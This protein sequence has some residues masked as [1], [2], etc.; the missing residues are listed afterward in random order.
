MN[1]SMRLD[2]EHSCSLITDHGSGGEEAPGVFHG[3]DDLHKVG[4]QHGRGDAESR[5]T[6]SESGC[7]KSPALAPTPMLFGVLSASV[8]AT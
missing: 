1:R 3:L 5:I 7:R 6:S 2:I 8:H 4:V